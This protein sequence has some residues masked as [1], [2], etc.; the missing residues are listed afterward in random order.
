MLFSWEGGPM[1]VLRHADTPELAELGRNLDG[2]RTTGAF[3]GLGQ[4]FGSRK[5]PGQRGK[6]PRLFQIGTRFPFWNQPHR[7]S[8][9]IQEVR[10]GSGRRPPEVPG[11]SCGSSGLNTR[12]TSS[13]RIL[14]FPVTAPKSA[15]SRECVLP[16]WLRVLAPC[17]RRPQ[18]TIGRVPR[19]L[20]RRRCNLRQREILRLIP[21]QT[22]R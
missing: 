9:S 14:L 5:E 22:T 6:P 13:L 10:K 17:Q 4:N 16:V 1:G 21:E 18:T 7:P 19:G 11:W 12:L 20:E 15:E 8:R 3:D 2:K